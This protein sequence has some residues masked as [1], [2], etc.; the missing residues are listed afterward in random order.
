MIAIIVVFVSI[1]DS[2]VGYDDQSFQ[3]FA[4]EQYYEAFANTEDYE[5]NILLVFLTYDGYDGYDCIPWGGYN[6]DAETEQLFGS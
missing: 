6:I 4:N 2:G 3:E 1:T 5:G